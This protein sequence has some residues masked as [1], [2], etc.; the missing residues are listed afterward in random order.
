MEIG[1]V[2]LPLSGKTTLFNLLTHAGAETGFGAGKKKANLGVSRVPDPRLDRL[3][4]MWSPKKTTPA[5]IR[6]V[7]VA[8]VERSA[9]KE[10][11]SAETLT[12][13]KNTDALLAVVRAFED[14]QVPHV[15]GTLD[16][17]RDLSML[18]SEFLLSDLIIVENRLE[19]LEKQIKTKGG[20]ELEA[21][22][23][24]LTRCREALEAETPLRESEFSAEEAR[25]LKG[26]Q[27][28]TQKPLVVALN[29][30]EAD[31][32]RASEL[33]APLAA[34][35]GTAHVAA[36]YLCATVEQ[37]ISELSAEDARAFLDDLGIDTSA[38]DRIIR[39]SYELLGLI[40]F[41]TMGEDECRAWTIRRG[42][43]APQAAG[44]IHTD[45]ERGFIRAEVVRYDD[46]VAA[47]S[48]PACRDKGLLRLEGKEYV[49]HD[50]DV[51]NIRFS[52]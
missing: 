34:R 3:S 17:L 27:F 6:Y 1:I 32:P 30:G 20:K 35:W 39:T 9:G 14:E 38:T 37:E 18:Q 51:L 42:T 5:T 12:H 26:F 7:D 22:H 50:G 11:L 4:E 29:L 33:L 44:T 47:G 36:T 15:E 24:L 41:F 45:L 8:G 48:L 16:P 43:K 49:V 10:G 31:I 46:F 52:V 19:R 28:L 40:S 25:L 21:E 13:L 2:G 23:V